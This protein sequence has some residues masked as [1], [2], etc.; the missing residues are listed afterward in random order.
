[1]E[2]DPSQ[3]G[4]EPKSARITRFLGAQAIAETYSVLGEGLWRLRH[5]TGI[6]RYYGAGGGSH[7][8][9]APLLFR[10]GR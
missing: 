6:I 4:W 8:T 3:Y 10:D 9:V 2:S 1:M 7:L 5:N